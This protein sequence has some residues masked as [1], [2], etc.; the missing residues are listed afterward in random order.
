MQ[1]KPYFQKN[2]LRLTFIT[3]KKVFLKHWIILISENFMPL[4]EPLNIGI[5]SSSL[6]EMLA[7]PPLIPYPSCFLRLLK[8]L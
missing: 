5:F 4:N 1:T 8:N 2:A 7:P 6:A 3:D